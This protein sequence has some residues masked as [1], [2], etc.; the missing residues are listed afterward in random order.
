MK[1]IVTPQQQKKRSKTVEATFES[2]ELDADGNH[3]ILIKQN[4]AKIVA[5]QPQPSSDLPFFQTSKVSSKS[6]GSV[7]GFAAN[8]NV[9]TVRKTN[10][11]RIS[12]ILNV[13]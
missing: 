5:K 12:I 13:I 7:K 2:F 3:P 10:E 8:T 11:D 4:I 6:F 1:T 9:G